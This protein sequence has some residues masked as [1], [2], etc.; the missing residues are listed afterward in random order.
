VQ[1]NVAF[2]LNYVPGFW[3]TRDDMLLALCQAL[4][5]RGV[6]PVLVTSESAPEA[7][8]RRFEAAGAKFEAI[9]YEKGVLSYAWGLRRVIRNYAIG[10]VHIRYFTCYTAVPW[11][12]RL[13]AVR[14]IVFTDAEPGMLTAA[15][16]Q[17][18]VL[19][20]RA[21]ILLMPV[22]RLIAISDF[23]KSRLL[24]VG[25]REEKVVVIHNGIDADY[26]QP[27]PTTRQAWVERFSLPPEDLVLTTVSFLLPHKE[28]EIL[29]E[30]VALLVERGIGVRL[31]VAGKGPLRAELEQLSKRLGIEDRTYWLGYVEDLRPLMQASDIF[32]LAS[33]GE[34]FGNVTAEAMACGVPAIVTRSGGS[35]DVVTDRETGYLLPTP[36]ANHFANAIETLAGNSGLRHEMGKRARERVKERF[37]LTEFAAKT[38]SVY[39]AMW[40]GKTSLRASAPARLSDT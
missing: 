22:R 36:T 40:N 24:G 2:L 23:V 11:L 1:E 25:V 34:G 39:E 35:G 31:F 28:I 10:T 14:H 9:N 30:T 26:Y 3:G 5:S 21:R 8:R 16:W 27:A 32:L 4:S 37:G 15:G 29:L 13:L 7:A 18:R 12:A 19:E 17:R 33:P 38:M 20:A 6:V